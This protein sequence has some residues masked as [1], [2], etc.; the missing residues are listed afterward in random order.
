MRAPRLGLCCV[1]LLLPVLAACGDEAAAPPAPPESGSAPFCETLDSN[2]P[3]YDEYCSTY[4]DRI[5]PS[6]TLPVR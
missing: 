4:S 2:D 3:R 6:D 5:R 1:A